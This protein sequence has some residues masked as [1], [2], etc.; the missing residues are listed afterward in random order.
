MFGNGGDDKAK[1]PEAAPAA[2]TYLLSRYFSC[3]G[4]I[5]T[6]AKPSAGEPD[7]DEEAILGEVLPEN[8]F[9]L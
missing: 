7:S 2:G 1:E 5:I 8:Q 9:L 4:M 3:D 6:A